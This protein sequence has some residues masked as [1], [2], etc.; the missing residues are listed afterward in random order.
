MTI[1]TTTTT[2]TAGVVA[3]GHDSD[4]AGGCPM[5]TWHLVAGKVN[6]KPVK[7]KLSSDF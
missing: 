3:A 2:T 1:N 6:E 4:G 7:S 5:L